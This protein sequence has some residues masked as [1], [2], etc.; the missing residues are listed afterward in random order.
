[1]PRRKFDIFYFL[2]AVLLAGS[3]SVGQ[4][5]GSIVL[6][7]T[8]AT[9]SQTAIFAS[10]ISYVPEVNVDTAISVSNVLA[11]PLSIGSGF[12]QM[13]SDRVGNL[14]FFLWRDDGELVHYA[15]GP[16][17]PGVGLDAEGN[18]G[19][20]MTYRVLLGEIVNAAGVT[21]GLSG[22]GWVVAHFDAVQGTASVT[23]FST[24][25]LSIPMQPDLGSFLLTSRAGVP[26]EGPPQ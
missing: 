14:E 9:T 7:G 10:F 23:D 18:L 19:P 5:A 3:F 15:T 2:A 8:A 1:M 13:H 25:S 20:G 6:N 11:A 21:G 17:S 12:D 16:D 24:F 4:Q 26:V 22:Y